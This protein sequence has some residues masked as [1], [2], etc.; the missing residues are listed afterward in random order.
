MPCFHLHLFSVK[1]YDYQR[2]LMCQT[3]LDQY[4]GKN[5]THTCRQYDVWFMSSGAFVFYMSFAI[6]SV[7]APHV[8]CRNVFS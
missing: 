7:G 4:D 6:S 5:R 1:R 2:C 3:H 8:Q